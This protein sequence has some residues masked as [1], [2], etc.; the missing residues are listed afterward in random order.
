MVIY[1]SAAIFVDKATD[2]CDKI[3]RIEQII[4]ALLTTAL[5]SAAH[6]EIEEYMLDD[7]QTKIKTIYK[8]TDQIF[9]S[10][11]SFERLKQIYVNRLNGRRLRLVDH[12]NFKRF[13][14][15]RH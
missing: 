4:D 10:I 5:S 14:N 8:G 11:D 15:G 13:R 1:D 9:K 12:N 6:D 7:G 2:L 3:V